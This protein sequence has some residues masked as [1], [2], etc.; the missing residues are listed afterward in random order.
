MIKP[1]PG[2]VLVEAIEDEGKDGD[3]YL[4]EKSKDK[5]MK[6]KV[7]AV[8]KYFLKEKDGKDWIKG[9]DMF[10]NPKDY[11]LFRSPVKKG[12]TVVHKKWTNE[13]VS[14]KGKEY[15]LVKFSELLAII[16]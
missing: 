11:F 2:Y 7:V 5:P 9:H 1:L 4:P 14:H 12:Q 16:E 13:T 6:G 10:V 3:L 8:G 15:L